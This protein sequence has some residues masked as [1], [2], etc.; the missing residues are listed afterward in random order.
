[1]GTAS[2]TSAPAERSDQARALALG[3]TRPAQR[4]PTGRAGGPGARPLRTFGKPLFDEVVGQDTREGPYGQEQLRERA[5]LFARAEQLV[6]G[7]SILT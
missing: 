5:G 3:K 4:G 1:V 2:D 7:G 6:H